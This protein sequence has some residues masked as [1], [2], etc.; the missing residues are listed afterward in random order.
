MLDDVTVLE[1]GDRLSTS[2]AGKMLRD[3]GATVV[4]V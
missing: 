2:F 1:V 4:G 3:A